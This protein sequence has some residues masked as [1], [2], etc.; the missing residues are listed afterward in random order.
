M[1]NPAS[2][3]GSVCYP[4]LLASSSLAYAVQ[5]YTHTL[6]CANVCV[7]ALLDPA[8]IHVCINVCFD[9][10]GEDIVNTAAN[11]RW[12]KSHKHYV[13]LLIYI[14]FIHVLEKSF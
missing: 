14:Y 10:L 6:A 1:Q 7:P 12:L 13:L 2:L 8:F 5:Q 9:Y 3:A 4:A 11:P